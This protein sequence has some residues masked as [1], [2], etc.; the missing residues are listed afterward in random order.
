[1]TEP[2]NA[3]LS[4]NRCFGCGLDNPDGM[5]IH[6]HRDSQSDR[7]LVGRYLPRSVHVGFPEIVHGGLQFTALDC[8]AGWATLT[9]RAPPW[10]MPLTTSAS[11]KFIRPAS[12][13]SDELVLDAEI[14][15]EPAAARDPIGI[16]AT[17]RTAHG[18]LLSEAMFEYVALPAEKFAKAVGIQE[19]PEHYRRYF[20]LVNARA[21]GGSSA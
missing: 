19:I 7:R 15:K 17:L 1:M 6:I 14:V 9:L 20:E 4:G 5:R 18:D 8:M 21:S 2:L 13:T 12:V 16:R 10:S 11:M 3:L